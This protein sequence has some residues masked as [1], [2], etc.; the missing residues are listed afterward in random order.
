MQIIKHLQE[1]WIPSSLL[2]V[3]DREVDDYNA[4]SAQCCKVGQGGVWW[5]GEGGEMFTFQWTGRGSENITL[6]K[7]LPGYSQSLSPSQALDGETM[8]DCVQICRRIKAQGI[9]GTKFSGALPKSESKMWDHEELYFSC[10]GIWP[11]LQH[12]EEILNAHSNCRE[13]SLAELGSLGWEWGLRGVGC[14][15][16][17]YK[18]KDKIW[19]RS[20]FNETK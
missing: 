19:E 7:Y 4:L 15:Q 6:R 3:R 8:G 5:W 12:C 11:L 18:V 9:S 14:N 16:H 10:S 13:F 20:A 1:R 2:G 17:S